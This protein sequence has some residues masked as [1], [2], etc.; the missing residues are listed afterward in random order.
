MVY[1]IDGNQELTRSDFAISAKVT[2]LTLESDE[3]LDSLSI[4]ATAAYGQS[5]KLSLAE[6]P[7]AGALTGLTITLD[8]RYPGLAI[9]QLAIVSG[10]RV[11]L[12]GGIGVEVRRIKEVFEDGDLEQDTTGRQF[13][14]LELDAPLD[15]QYEI[16][17][18]VISANVVE[19]T[20]GETKAE[21]LGSGDAKTTNQTFS[22][23]HTPLTYTSADTPTGA[24]SSLEVRVNDL[25][26]QEAPNLYGRGPDER[27]YAVRVEDDGKT[28]VQFNSR[29]PTGQE[30]V[31]A[32]YRQGIGLAGRVKAN[33]LSLLA[34]RPLGVRGVTNP[35][36][37]SGGQDPENPAEI[38]RNA[39]LTALTL[40]RLVSLRDYE[41]FARS[42]AGFAKARATLTVDGERQ[43]I[44]IT[45]AGAGGAAPDEKSREFKNLVAAMKSFGDPNVSFV[46]KPYRPAFF[47]V[48][49]TIAVDPAYISEK[50]VAAV[51]AALRRTFSFEARDFGQPVQKSEVFAA[52]QSVAGVVFVDLDYLFRT[53]P[54]SP[55]SEEKT[56]VDRLPAALPRA[57]IRSAEAQPAEIL[58]L[59]YR[60][61]QIGVVA[62]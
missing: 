21:I 55:G 19:A 31:R 3:G 56:L 28:R 7:I 47:Q 32:R 48:Q 59:D 51:E 10:K 40:D 50:V 5:E 60:P 36:E 37:S 15:F 54:E 45:V 25:L 34:V 49:G 13:T 14:R 58:T 1:G 9:G 22:L 4:R 18:V 17:S 29:L 23:K 27:V 30:N 43:G 62:Q 52:I 20:H 6:I 39:P 44:F 57:G 33:Q 38:R 16:E 12:N 53:I 24:Q 35:L 26:W 42:F 41:D 46:V 11:D 8:K 61:V 2:R